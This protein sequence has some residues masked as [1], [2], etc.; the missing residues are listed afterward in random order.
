MALV[1]SGVALAN[2]DKAAEKFGMPMGPIE[3]IDS[4]G[5]DVALNVSKVLGA[6][7]DR[8]IPERLVT[9]VDEGK[10]GRKTGEG[11]YLWEGKKATKPEA[12]GEVPGDIEDRLV[13]P[14]V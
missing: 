1:E 4:V 7:M 11:F 10:L 9:M 3:L 6:A 13:L 12:G 14:M 8:P 2:I 5:L